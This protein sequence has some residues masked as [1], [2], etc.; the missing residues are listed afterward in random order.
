MS[1]NIYATSRAVLKKNAVLV[2]LLAGALGL[3]VGLGQPLGRLPGFVD[4]D[5]IITLSGLLLITTG[6]KESGLFYLAAYRI[7][8][9]IDNERLLALFLF[10]HYPDFSLLASALNPLISRGGF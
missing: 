9:R 2:V 5:T 1:D 8:Q 4:W 7:I 10:Y 3:S 6:I